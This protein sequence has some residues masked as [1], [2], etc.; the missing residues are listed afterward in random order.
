MIR[1][2]SESLMG[3]T[4]FTILNS[5]ILKNGSDNFLLTGE[6]LSYSKCNNN[7]LCCHINHLNETFENI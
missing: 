1:E 4:A 2:M 6:P 3:I 7:K 5:D